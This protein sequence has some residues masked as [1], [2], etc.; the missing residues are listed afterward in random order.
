MR[1]RA[2]LE[3]EKMRTGHHW[4]IGIVALL[5]A[6]ALLT[7]CTRASGSSA[8]GASGSSAQMPS[9]E[10]LVLG[11]PATGEELFRH[12]LQ[13]TSGRAPT[14]ITC[15]AVDAGEPEMV[16]PTLRGVA[17]TAG[18]RIADTPAEQY[19]CNSIIRPNDY[20]VSGYS[21]G[22]MPRTYV[23]YLSQQQVNDLVAYM[24]TLEQ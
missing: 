18:T 10:N 21:S 7:A 11:D 5:A 14:C 6:V 22:I 3:R 17:I 4:Q 19:L 15:H 13:M 16:G 24:A 23:L 2:A 1:S 12:T 9:C 20:I 8:P